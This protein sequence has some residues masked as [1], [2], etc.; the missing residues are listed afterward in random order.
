MKFLIPVITAILVLGLLVSVAVI[1]YFGLGPRLLS[2]VVPTI[3]TSPTDAATLMTP[4]PM[5]PPLSI[6]D[7]QIRQILT[8]I[9]ASIKIPTDERPKIEVVKNPESL[10]RQPFFAAV[11]ANDLVVLF[12]KS[13][14]VVLFRPGTGEV[15]SSGT[16]QEGAPEAS[17]SAHPALI[18]PGLGT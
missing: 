1:A 3:P 14:Q 12:Q 4:T 11:Q 2:P 16:V 10:K 6:T 13:R 7:D 9:S 5:A 15:V 18:V 17:S 8:R